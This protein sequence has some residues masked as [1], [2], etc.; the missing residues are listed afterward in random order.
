VTEPAT[1]V[2]RLGVLDRVDTQWRWTEAG[3]LPGGLDLGTEVLVGTVTVPTGTHG[4]L[5][6]RAWDPGPGGG[7][8]IVA[9]QGA[10]TSWT[11]T[12]LSGPPTEEWQVGGVAAGSVPAVLA[13]DVA[14]RLWRGALDDTWTDLGPPAVDAA[15]RGIAAGPVRPGG[16]LAVAAGDGRRLWALDDDPA[17][18]RWTDVPVL[19]VAVRDVVGAVAEWNDPTSPEPGWHLF[20]IGTDGRLWRAGGTGDGGRGPTT[21]ARRPW[22]GCSPPVLVPGDPQPRLCIWGGD[23]QVWVRSFTENGWSWDERGLSPGSPA[24]GFVT[25]LSARPPGGGA[26]E[27]LV[28]FVIDQ[29]RKLWGSWHDGTAPRW[30]DLDTLGSGFSIS[31]GLG[32]ATV[33]ATPGGPPVVRVAVLDGTARRLRVAPWPPGPPWL[34]HPLPP[35]AIADRLGVLPAPDDAT[36]VLVA[37]VDGRLLAAWPE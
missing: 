21:A 6:A 8:R 36:A 37:A 2:T 35:A 19:P 17:G 14:G 1:G 5:V 11:W 23:G 4:C 24:F 31:A 13:Y 12:V 27:G 33:D 10:G 7:P 20:V 18:P 28:A 30:T 29:D 22:C 32:A 15:V 26:A 34:G 3:P 25:A 16:P 9:L